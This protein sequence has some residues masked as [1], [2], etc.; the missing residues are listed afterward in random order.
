MRVRRDD[1][2]YQ[3]QAAAEAEFW[4]NP[5]FNAEIFEAGHI[6]ALKRFIDESYTG[7]PTRSWMEDLVRRGPFEHAAVLGS[8]EG[9]REA[10]WL[11]A[12]GSR[13][14]DVYDISPAVLRKARARLGRRIGPLTLPPRGVR[15]FVA[16]LNFVALPRAR[17]D[18]IWT[19]AS[20][21]HV[22]NLEYLFAEVESALRPGGLFAIHDYTGEPR[23]RYAPARLE[24]GNALLR[25]VPERLRHLPALVPPPESDM[26][27]FEAL[28]SDETLALARER[29]DLVHL[30]EAD[31]LYPLLLLVDFPR[32]EKEDPGLVQELL[33]GE[34]AARRTTLRKCSM[35]AVF[36]K[37]SG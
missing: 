30:A 26:S 14:L 13:R 31:A 36:R 27:P 33:E 19:S 25:R 18:V 21:H 35:Y 8:T 11:A 3:R 15:F 2:A 29:F 37:R 7:D 4:A 16:D 34:R 5:P 32:L 20:L 1:P 28:R 6:G 9:A 10:A 24:A 22:T 23:L 12:C 17:Y